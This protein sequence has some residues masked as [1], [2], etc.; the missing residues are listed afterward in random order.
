MV[1]SLLFVFL[2]VV[3]RTGCRCIACGKS[4]YSGAHRSGGAPQV[5]GRYIFENI[6]VKPDYNSG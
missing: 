6:F 3:G 2:I 4:F 1:S 5:F